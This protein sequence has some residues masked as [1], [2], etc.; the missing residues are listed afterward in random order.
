[1]AMVIETAKLAFGEL[2]SVVVAQTMQSVKIKTLL[3]RVKTTLKSIEPIF[4]EIWRLRK[5]LDRPEEETTMFISHLEEGKELIV[6]YSRIKFWNIY[7]KFVYSNK[8]IR[9]NNDLLW[10]FQIEL[11]GNSLSTSMR[12]LIGIHDLSDKMDQLLSAITTHARA[13]DRSCRV[14]RLPEHIVG[15]KLHLEELK[16]RLLNYDTEVLV[17]SGPGGCGK[18]TLAKMLCHDNE[19]KEIFGENILYVTVSRQSSLKIIMEK[20]FEHYGENHCEFQTDEEGRNHLE[21]LINQM[22]SNKMLLVLDDVWSESESI[23]QDLMFQIQGC[24]V[25]VTSRFLFPRFSST[26]ELSLLNYEDARTLF[27]YSAFP[28]DR[29]PINVTDDLMNK[30][31]KFCK[32]LPLALTVVGASLCGQPVLKWKTTL[33]KWSESGSILQSNINILH[34][35]KS[36]VDALDELSIAKECFLDLGS[37]PEAERISAMVLMDMWV[38]LYNLDDEGMHTSETL[39]ELSLR[40]LINLVPLRKYAGEL[41][42]YC[43]EL[44][45]TQH[46]LLR[47][48]A[49]HMSSQEPIVERKRLFVDIHRNEFPT[50]WIS[51][52]EQPINAR[53]LSISTDEAFGSMWYDLKAPKIEVLILNIRSTKYTLAEFIKRM[54]QLKFLT[55]TS[56]SDYPS[57]LHNLYLIECL[58]N[59]RTI[60]FEHVLVSSIQPIFALRNLRKLSLVMC[61]I[62]NALTSS[63]TE[64]PYILSNIRELE[65]DMCYDLKELPLGLCSLVNLEK[66]SITNCQEFDVLPKGFGCLSNLEILRLH[67]C[68]K[69]QELPESIGS[70]CNLSFIDISDCLSIN[71]LPEE[72]GELCGLRVLKMDGCSGLQ[73]LPVSMSKLLQLEDV[74]CDEETSYLWMEFKSFIP[75]LK[76]NVVED[77]RFE[78]FMKIVQ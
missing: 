70:L 67:C 56:Y 41:D 8:L 69:L 39:H 30:I 73:E 60:R 42:G 76:I 21:K 22:G 13:N 58:S 32:G 10:F 50:W 2:L 7:Q 61:E 20:I 12:S 35:L 46:D 16:R 31:V 40:N 52:T 65:I 14:P 25:L 63:I 4:F 29:I 11:Q 49:I 27:C 34:S 37:F 57:Q 36:S 1:M 59:L 33:K 3:K 38:E 24:K 74:I 47:E 64:T 26:Y 19:M 6:K 15:F 43:N 66:L 78:S 18:T 62:G 68:T 28:S 45:V 44:F 5:V 48:L 77:D 55:I 72:V 17:V 75:N 54:D 71:V 23:I 9:L 53:I 51:E